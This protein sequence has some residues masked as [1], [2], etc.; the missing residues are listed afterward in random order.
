[1]QE[2]FRAVLKVKNAQECA[3]F[4]RDLMTIEEI[5]EMANRWKA[6]RLLDDGL[7]YRDVAF[8]T[9]MSTTTVARIAFWLRDGEGGYRLVLDRMKNQ[10]ERRTTVRSRRVSNQQNAHHSHHPTSSYEQRT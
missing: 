7:T 3:R 8:K 2:L 4:F 10:A 1:M 6:A 5:R 9:G